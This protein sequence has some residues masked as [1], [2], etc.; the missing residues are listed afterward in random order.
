VASEG[1][2]DAGF[3]SPSPPDQCMAD[4]HFGDP[5]DSA[6]PA[7]TG[8]GHPQVCAADQCAL[9]IFDVDRSGSTPST[10]PRSL[11]ARRPAAC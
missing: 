11:R 1:W 8:F 10:C 2:S 7:L 6:C 9:N 5:L 4:R 3:W